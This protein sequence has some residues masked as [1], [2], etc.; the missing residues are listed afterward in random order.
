[1]ILLVKVVTVCTLVI[2]LIIGRKRL[3]VLVMVMELAPTK[4]PSEAAAE[5]AAA[6]I[7]FQSVVVA[8]AA[9]PTVRSHLTVF[10]VDV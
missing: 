4:A 6:L 5:E 9:L 1:M 3:T 7:P 8:A 10:S 2:H